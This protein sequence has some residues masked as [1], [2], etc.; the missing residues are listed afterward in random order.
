[1]TAYDRYTEA[2][3]AHTIVC[4]NAKATQVERF[5]AAM[6][7]HKAFQAFLMAESGPAAVHTHPMPDDLTELIRSAFS[8]VHAIRYMEIFNIRPDGVDSFTHDAGCCL[9]SDAEAILKAALVK[10]GG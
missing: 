2:N 1:M 9:L 4:A 6:A 7:V 8:M 3:A 5:D 10:A